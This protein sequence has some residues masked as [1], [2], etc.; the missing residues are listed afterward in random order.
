MV[1]DEQDLRRGLKF[2]VGTWQVDYVVN[3]FSNDLA[4]IPAKEFKSEDGRDF[5]CITFEFFEDHT[6]T[7]RDAGSGK[8]VQGTWEQTDWSEF[9]Y[10]LNGFIDLP[11]GDFKK[12]A[13]TLSVT[14]DH[15]VF[16]I[17][18]LAVALNKIAEGT[19]TEQPDIGERE[20]SPEDLAMTGIVGRWSTY[21]SFAAVG[22]DFGAF[23]REEVQAEVDKKVAAGEMDQEEAADALKGFETVVEFT[24]DHKVIFWMKLPAGVS[25]DMIK[26][27][28]EAGEI[29]AVENGMFTAEEKEW[30]ALDGKY[31]Y[32]S[33]EH[34][35]TFGEVQSPW[36]ELT[37]AE[38]G[39]ME[40]TSGMMVLKKM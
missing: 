37:V 1:L 11:E 28:L 25:E 10:T 39:T 15:L 26:E 13:E 21:K 20:S 38:D 18:F 19:V 2:I 35:E 33:G 24:P 9:H 30:K 31:Y 4:H 7:M 16:S 22:D 29:K 40:M 36:D 12:N 34:R 32:N 3:A 14:E 17:A 8:E 27:A 23:T 5:S 6:L